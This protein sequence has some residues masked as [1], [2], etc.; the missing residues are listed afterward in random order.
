MKADLV[1]AKLPL[2]LRHCGLAEAVF[3]AVQALQ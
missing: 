3:T 1:E 2:P